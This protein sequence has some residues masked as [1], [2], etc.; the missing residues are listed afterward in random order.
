MMG[1]AGGGADRRASGPL[2]KSNAFFTNVGKIHIKMLS[3]KSLNTVSCSLWKEINK[4]REQGYQKIAKRNKMIH[5][6]KKIDPCYLYLDE[7]AHLGQLDKYEV[8]IAVLQ[9]DIEDAWKKEVKSWKHLDS[10]LFVNRANTTYKKIDAKGRRALEREPCVI[11]YETHDAKHL[12]TTNCGHTF[13]RPCFSK[14]LD[15]CY[16]D[17]KEVSC[18]YCRNEN[19]LLTRYYK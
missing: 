4:H 9:S 14:V 19:I 6:P 13:C 16:Y 3:L 8:E 15:T 12:T 18:P 1:S 10:L 7:Y 5:I 2:I 17:H 11:C